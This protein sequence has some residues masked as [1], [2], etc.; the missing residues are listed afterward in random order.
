MIIGSIKKLVPFSAKMR[1]REWVLTHYGI[2]FSRFDVPP[3]L[4]GYLRGRGAISL[5]DIGASSGDFSESIIKFCGVRNGLLIEPIPRRCEEL[6]AKFTRDN[7]EIIC[8]AVGEKEA[9]LEMEVLKWDYASS[10]LP[11]S[12]TDSMVTS[13]LDLGVK[14]KV[15]TR[16]RSL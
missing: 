9:E 7:F 5:I 8:G 3:P 11:V 13:L 2:P 16:V 6:R 15:K 10:I 1:L 4:V 14:E 12:R